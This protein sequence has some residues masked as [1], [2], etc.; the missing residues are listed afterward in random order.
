MYDPDEVG[1]FD[2]LASRWWDPQGPFSTL[3][4]LNPLRLQWIA[5]RTGCQGC[6]GIDVGCGGG[7][8]T[9][10]LATLGMNMTGIDASASAIFVAKA[11]AAQSGLKINYYNLRS[12]EMLNQLAD[13]KFACVTCLELLEH[14]PEPHAVV[15]DCAKLCQETGDV[16]FSTLNRSPKAF[17]QAIVGAEYLL[18]IVP[19]GTHRYDWFIRPSELEAWAREVGLRLQS[20]SGIDYNPLTK[21]FSLTKNVHVNYI[22]HF[23]KI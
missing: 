17:L 11:H 2:A 19:K 9:E 22:A 20:M 4:A 21:H 18:N 12:D 7:L 3:H 1:K 16:F 13:Q 10:G 23:K 8:L 14:V 6:P 5:E 15:S